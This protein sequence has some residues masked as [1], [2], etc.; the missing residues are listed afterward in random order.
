MEDSGAPL[1]GTGSHAS[2]EP[3]GLGPP[4]FD[5]SRGNDT[6][7]PISMAPK[8]RRLILLCNEQA[9]WPVMFGRWNGQSWQSVDEGT[10]GKKW[11]VL[12]WRYAPEPGPILPYPPTCSFCGKDSDEVRKLIAGP[13]VMI[14]DECVVLCRDILEQEP[15][16][17]DRSPKGPDPQGLDGEAATAGAEG[18]AKPL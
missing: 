16:D 3:V 4:G 13:A 14:C 7:F 18:I 10:S 15:R 9:P 1:S 6:W 17:T 5:P 2:T 11:N 8:D 12:G